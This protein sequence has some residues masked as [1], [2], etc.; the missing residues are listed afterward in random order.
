MM[1]HPKVFLNYNHLIFHY[2]IILQPLV[3]WDWDQILN[4]DVVTR[5]IQSLLIIL[6]KFYRYIY[7]IQQF[8]F[9]KL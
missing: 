7:S 1:S 9:S 5:S 8:V 6:P 3:I 4:P 2:Y